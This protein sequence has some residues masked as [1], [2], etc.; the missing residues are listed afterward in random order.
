M[1]LS[2]ASGK[3]G[4]GKT[5]VAVNLALSIPNA[6]LLDCD[7]EAP[8][9]H[10]FLKPALREKKPA[11]LLLPEIDLSKC[12]LCGKCQEICAYHALAV[13][14]KKVLVFQEL[15]HS[16]GACAS[17]CPRNAIREVPKEIGQVELG[18][19]N[20][21]LFGHGR[22]YIGEMMSPFLIQQVRKLTVPDRTVVIDAP[23]GTSCPMIAAVRQSDFCILVTEP[24][25]FGLNDLGLAVEVVKRLGIPLGVIL[26]RADENNTEV[27]TFCKARKIP[28]LLSIPFERRIA[29]LYSKG[30]PLVTA[31]PSYQTIFSDLRDKIF[32]LLAGSAKA[33]RKG[34]G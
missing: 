5:T 20:G 8:N 31:D 26:N 9:A 1:I 15:C 6:Q 34:T 12:D 11:Q 23:P 3:G 32:A 10:L 19:S 21:L 7:V 22:L 30:I 33:P 17:L 18:A 28:V 27:E 24:T 29:E 16:C 4:T 2:V 13:L 14:P 25:P